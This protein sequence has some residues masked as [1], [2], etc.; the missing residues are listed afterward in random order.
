MMTGI[1]KLTF[2]FSLGTL[3]LAGCGSSNKGEL[4]GVLNREKWFQPDPYGMVYIPSGSFNMG[5]SDQ[6]VPYA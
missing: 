1:K 4:T 5:P 3:A 6:D 2:L